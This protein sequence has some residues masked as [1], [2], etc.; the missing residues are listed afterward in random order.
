MPIHLNPSPNRFVMNREKSPHDSH[1]PME[2]EEISY[3]EST[4]VVKPF[5]KIEKE[6]KDVESSE[7]SR[8]KKILRESKLTKIFEDKKKAEPEAGDNKPEIISEDKKIEENKPR[9]RNLVKLEESESDKT[10]KSTVFYFWQMIFFILFPIAVLV[11]SVSIARE[12]FDDEVCAHRFNAS[13]AIRDLESRVF[14]QTRAIRELSSHLALNSAN[15]KVLALIGGTGVGKSYAAH[16]IGENFTAK[17]NVFQY[18][19]PLKPRRR[20]ALGAVSICGCN[21]IILENLN[22]KD[23]PEAAE[24]VEHLSRQINNDNYCVFIIEVINVHETDGNLKHETDL[25]KSTEEIKRVYRQL[26]LDV[27]IVRFEPLDDETITKCILDVANT[28]NLTLSESQIED[29][30]ISLKTAES[31]CKGAQAKVQ[32]LDKKWS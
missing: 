26:N 6:S 25:A 12:E 11:A 10:E 13:D 8:P 2:I 23:V 14:G 21:L 15:F 5:I 28:R 19:P 22:G 9:L 32:L 4:E 24:F 7:D 17:K 31:G 3:T 16:I 29:V 20:F 1:E 30:R 18:V 27:K